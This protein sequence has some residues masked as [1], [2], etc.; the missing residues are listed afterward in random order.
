[1]NNFGIRLKGSNDWDI[2]HLEKIILKE[3]GGEEAQTA[4]KTLS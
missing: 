1:V 4:I 2:L 3:S